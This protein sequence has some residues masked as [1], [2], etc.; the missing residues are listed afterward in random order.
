[1]AT[2][3]DN[4]NVAAGVTVTN[5]LAGSKFEFMRVPSTV[6]VYAKLDIINTAG[7]QE[8]ATMTVS[9][10]NVVEGDTLE[11]PQVRVGA[12]GGAGSGVGPN[13][14]EDLLVSGVADAGDRL[15]IQITNT[16]DAEAVDVRTL[17]KISPIGM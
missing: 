15:Q 5:I 7:A 9:F 12:L 16:A 3:R 2:I 14:N 4:R 10:G 6:L 13:I 1:M 8:G 17:V 11:I